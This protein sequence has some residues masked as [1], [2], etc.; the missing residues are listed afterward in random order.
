MV[1][2]CIDR[3]RIVSG[4]QRIPTVSSTACRHSVTAYKA[5]FA[6]R[7]TAVSGENAKKWI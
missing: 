5:V 7:I 1:L 3:P 4:G 2:D 6:P